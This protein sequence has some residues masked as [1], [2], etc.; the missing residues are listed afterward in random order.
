[1]GRLDQSTV[2]IVSDEA[3]FSRSITGRWQSEGATP[4]FTLMS[5]DLCHSLDDDAF[6][7]AI[8]GDVRPGMLPAVLRALDPAKPV[9]LI[10]DDAQNLRQARDT[11]PGIMALRKR[12]GWLD[13]LVLIV[14]EAMRRNE[15]V[16]RLRRSEEA[17]GHLLQQ[18]ALGNYMR[19]MLHNL[20]NALTSVLG[21]SELLLLEPNSLASSAQSQIETIRNMA[22]RMHE[23]LQRFS[24]LEKELKVVAAQSKNDG[25][26]KPRSA[27]AAR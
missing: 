13:A 6:D 26:A 25:H 8:V 9:L 4:T 2:L 14:S 5:G 18:A 15:A 12:D 7:V 20:N 19:E 16:N 10:C 1:M 11:Q 21:N 3:E 17:N 27:G 23:V 22:L 24:S